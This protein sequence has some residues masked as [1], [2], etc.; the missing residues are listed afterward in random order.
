MK[1]DRKLEYYAYN[2]YEKIDKYINK[3]AVDK[4]DVVNSLILLL[5]YILREV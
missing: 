1:I 3:N 5:T 4:V 2:F